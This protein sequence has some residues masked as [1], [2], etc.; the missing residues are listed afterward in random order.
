MFFRKLITLIALMGFCDSVQAQT[1]G[2]G[3]KDPVSKLFNP[4]AVCSDGSCLYPLTQLPPLKIHEL[5]A[6]IQETSGLLVVNGKVFTHNDSGNPSE[7]YEISEDH[8]SIIH[9]IKILDNAVDPD[10][11]DITTDGKYVY[12]SDAGNNQGNRQDLQ[13]LRIPV[14]Q[15]HQDSVHP[16]KIYFRYADQYSFEKS[17]KHHFD[18]EALI[19]LNDTIHLFSKNRGDFYSKHYILPANPGHH[20]ATL[21]DSFNAEMLVTSAALSPDRRSLVLTGYDVEGND[22]IYLIKDFPGTDF[23]KGNKRKILLGSTQEI[24]QLEAVTFLN[25]EY[26]LLSNESVGQIINAH[27]WGLDLSGMLHALPNSFL[28]RDF[29]VDMNKYPLPNQHLLNLEIVTTTQFSADI[30]L[31]QSNGKIL[32]TAPNYTFTNGYNQIK[33][34]PDELKKGDYIILIRKGVDNILCDKFSVR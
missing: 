24:G 11:E 21:L 9:T 29:F 18:C 6:K 19:V 25:D 33:L 34:I 5:P 2:C 26:V 23:L 3:C 8:D 7:V 28:T 1:K 16:E 10:W 14:S 20:V 4:E 15:L 12:L 32:A 17:K 31:I 22:Y 30:Y 27:L 13:I